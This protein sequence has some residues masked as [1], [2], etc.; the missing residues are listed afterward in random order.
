MTSLSRVVYDGVST[1]M[2]IMVSLSHVV[3]GV[4]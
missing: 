3:Y 1:G 4:G 2:S